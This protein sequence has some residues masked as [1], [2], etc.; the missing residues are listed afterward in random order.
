[1]TDNPL[2]F[3]IPDAAHGEIRLLL[4]DT[5]WT[6][7]KI[8]DFSAMTLRALEQQRRENE[9]DMW[10][11]IRR[12]IPSVREWTLAS[13]EIESSRVI[14]LDDQNKP[15]E[16][17]ASVPPEH[18]REINLLVEQIDITEA[19]MGRV[20]LVAMN[21]ESRVDRA[22]Q[23]LW[24]VIQLHVPMVKEPG[25]WQID[26]REMVVYRRPINPQEETAQMTSS[27]D[28]EQAEETES[29]RETQTDQR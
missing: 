7:A 12:H 26:T 14:R 6:R 28:P 9:S 27:H 16:E 4:E 15:T 5:R 29:S 20:G 19:A 2:V 21:M 25:Q 8:A 1:M 10:A 13:Y 17:T 22:M 18:V 24:S 23:K 11:T 3:S